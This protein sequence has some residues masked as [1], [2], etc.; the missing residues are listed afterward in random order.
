GGRVWS[1]QHQ[2]A[3]AEQGS[4][5]GRNL[6]FIGTAFR[7]CNVSGSADIHDIHS[8]FEG[9]VA[10]S[11]HE[12]GNIAGNFM[13]FLGAGAENSSLRA[14]RAGSNTNN[15]YKISTL[16]DESTLDIVEPQ[17]K[18]FGRIKISRS[19]QVS[20]ATLVET[21]G[22]D[23]QNGDHFTIKGTLTGFDVS[24]PAAAAVYDFLAQAYR[25]DAGVSGFQ[26]IRQNGGGNADADIALAVQLDG[27]RVKTVARGIA[28]TQTKLNAE[29]EVLAA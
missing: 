16:L 18:L 17:S 6:H 26:I 1:H 15:S 24:A 14:K 25:D 7:S 20:D 28:A 11:I 9:T 13:V 23:L 8:N 3:L 19:R 10:E 21:W 27:N 5:T 2:G 4:G 22:H 29:I 12:Y